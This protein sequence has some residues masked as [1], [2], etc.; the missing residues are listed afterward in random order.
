M[1]GQTAS[2][3]VSLVR[4]WEMISGEDTMH[5][6][7]KCVR[8]SEGVRKFGPPRVGIAVTPTSNISGYPQQPGP[9]RPA[10]Y[11][12]VVIKFERMLPHCGRIS[13]EVRKKFMG[14]SSRSPSSQTGTLGL[15]LWQFSSITALPERLNRCA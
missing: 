5:H 1:I 9:A 6:A 3:V 7:A 14:Q 12:D 4:S 11:A 2:I 10:L 15:P 13:P 8:A